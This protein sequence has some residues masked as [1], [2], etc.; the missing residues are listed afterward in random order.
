MVID[1]VV[2]IAIAGMAVGIFVMPLC[3]LLPNGNAVANRFLVPFLAVL[4]LSLLNNFFLHT[5]LIQR[6]PNLSAAG[7]FLYFALGPLLYLYIKALSEPRFA[8]RRTD[9]LHFVPVLVS[10]IAFLPVYASSPT[11]KSELA[12]LYFRQLAT[13]GAAAHDKMS[14]FA[15][16]PL[17]MHIHLVQY[18]AL[19]A[20][21]AVYAVL[22]LRQLRRHGAAIGQ[23]FSDIDRIQLNWLKYLCRLTLALCVASL[24]MLLARIAYADSF[25]ANARVLPALIVALLIY[26][27]GL[28]SLRQPVIYQ[29]VGASESTGGA[30][31]IANQSSS[32][33]GQSLDA[34]A[35]SESREKYQSSGL[36]ATEAEAHWQQLQVYM[37]E[38]RP[39]LESGLTIGELAEIFGI[40]VAHLSQ[41]V[42]SCAGLNFFD[43]INRYRVQHAQ[44]LLADVQ[45]GDKTVLDIALEAGFNSQS[46]FYAQFKKWTGVTP[47]QYRKA[48]IA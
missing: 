1:W 35:H 33:P 23:A 34:S 46:T 16:L 9:W 15:Q 4:S 44:Q 18:L 43:F 24:L 11:E 37:T 39:Y 28:L 13:M 5:G 12:A 32:G 22:G 27:V 2:V 19:M 48:P 42:N 10:L 8:F 17:G 7:Q 14:A 26:Y 41:V 36:T 30:R 45:G 47:S 38:R 29:Q 40:S 25:S 20:H 3:Y 21:I 31:S 6:F